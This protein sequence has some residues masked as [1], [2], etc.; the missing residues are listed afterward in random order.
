MAALALLAPI[1][2]MLTKEKAKVDLAEVGRLRKFRWRRRR[3][4]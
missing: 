3:W 2:I 4:I 1:S